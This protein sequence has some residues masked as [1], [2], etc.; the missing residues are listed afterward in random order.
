MGLAPPSRVAAPRL[1]PRKAEP[2]MSPSTQYVVFS[3]DAQRYALP[4]A[5]VQRTVRMVALVPLP[6]APPS[7]LGVVNVQGE[8]VP[9]VDTRRCFHLPERE[10]RL[11]DQLILVRVSGRTLALVAD[12]VHG[13]IEP[14]PEKIVGADRILPGLD[15]L[16]GAAKLE[17]GMVL[18]H[19]LEQIDKE[20]TLRVAART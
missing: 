9:V 13:V 2:H 16:R 8:V 12:A 17:D 14:A 19:D 7:V 6:E 10:P 4:L 5:N 15:Q 1:V 3:I 18:I 20:V 11:D